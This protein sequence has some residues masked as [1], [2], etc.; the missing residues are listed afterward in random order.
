[1]AAK[2]SDL[3]KNYFGEFR[4]H[5]VAFIVQLMQVKQNIAFKVFRFFGTKC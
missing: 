2:Y 1:L 5:K 3:N 4:E